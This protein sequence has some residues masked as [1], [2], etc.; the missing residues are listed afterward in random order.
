MAK[1]EAAC[2]VLTSGAASVSPSRDQAVGSGTGAAG[3]Q[4]H[5]L[6]VAVEGGSLAQLDQHDVVVQGV[7]VVAGVADDLGGVD[8]LLGAL[9]DGDVVLTKTHLDLAAWQHPSWK[10]SRGE[11]GFRILI[12]SATFTYDL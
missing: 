3:G 10:M 2:L 8:E 11:G 9:A 7:A 4:G 12:F 5:G 6:D 1:H